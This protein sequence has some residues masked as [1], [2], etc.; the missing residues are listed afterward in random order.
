MSDSLQRV[1]DDVVAFAKFARVQLYPWQVAAFSEA[2][3]RVGGRFRHRLAGVSVPRGNGKSYAAALVGLWRLFTG[4]PGQDVLS[5]ALDYAGAKVSLDHGRS[6]LRG[7]PTLRD[8]VEQRADGFVVPSTGSRWEVKPA[9][10]TA[11]RGRHPT[12]V[13]YDECGWAASDE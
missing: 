12:L 7:C 5:V 9:E 10:H 11:S 8:V 4:P 6:I 2:C 1:R 3:A 13:L